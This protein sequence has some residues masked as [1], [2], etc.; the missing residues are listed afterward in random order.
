[1]AAPAEPDPVELAARA[2]RHRDRSRADL[3]ARL[4]KAGVD[5]DRRADALETLARVGYVDDGRFAA[6]RA[7]TL[8]ERGLGDEAIRFDLEGH[9]VPREEL[10]AAIATLDQE[11]ERAVGIAA[12][13]GKNPKTAARLARQGFAPESIE[14]AIGYDVAGGDA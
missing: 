12:R 9:G 2:L 4:A 6:A 10:E 14:A 11:R 8:A 13:L 7:A 1:M 5:G 3:D